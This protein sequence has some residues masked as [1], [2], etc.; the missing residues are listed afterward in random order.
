GGYFSSTDE[1]LKLVSP[2]SNEREII[3][4]DASA[5][6]GSPA[7]DAVVAHELQHLIHWHADDSEESWVNEG[8][9]QVAFEM[10]T[11][12][13]GSVFPFLNNP[14]TQLNYWV[15]LDA[16]PS[17]HYAASQLFFRY[18]L[19]NYGGRE[20]AKRL[21]AQPEDGIAGI[22]RYLAPF[23]TDFR[24]V[25][26]D[27]L[28]AN[29]LDL[30]SGPYSHAGGDLRVSRPAT[31]SRLAGSEDRVSQFG[32]DYL[33]IKPESGGVFTFEGSPTVPAV[34]AEPRSGRSFWWSNRSD[35]VDTRLTREID[36]RGV[37]RATLNFWAWYDIEESWDFAYVAVSTDN[38]RT[39]KALPASTT[40]DHDP[41]SVAYGPGFTGR[42]GGPEGPR[43][44]EQTVDLT[45]F[46]GQKA[47][48]RF[49]YVT[50][51]STNLSGLAVDDISIPEIGLFDGAESDGPW[52]REGFLRITGPLPQ[53]FIVLLIDRD[54]SQ[55]VKRLDLDPQNRARLEVSRPVTIVIAGATEVTREKALYRWSFL[56]S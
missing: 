13:A 49:E 1:Y 54:D 34:A 52:Q 26:S 40:T 30:P 27:W 9:S 50:D 47:L 33:E 20:Q 15:T 8:L 53:Q 23:N 38:G 12:D 29:Y 42:S 5:P 22:D 37:A 39:W 31:I 51:D 18:L 16:D 55:P 11:G 32:A 21:L 36:L 3:Y 46:A 4:I 35:N 45:P 14:D 10:L 25:F 48:L 43:W 19:D 17:V 2:R 41:L 56:P 28:A 24:V 6:P 7:F 44:L